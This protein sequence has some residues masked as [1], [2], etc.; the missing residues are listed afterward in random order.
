MKNLIE[1]LQNWYSSQCN[2]VWEHSFGIEITNIDN[3]GWKIKITGANNKS[4]LNINVE[5]SDTDWIVIKADDTAF[6]AYGGSL[7]LQELLE[8]AAKWLE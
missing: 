4:N 6:Q 7:N 3:P 1:K 5:R 2:D 8:A